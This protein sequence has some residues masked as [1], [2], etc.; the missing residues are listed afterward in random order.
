[1]NSAAHLYGDRSYDKTI[2]PAENTFVEY[3]ALGEGY[4]NYHHVFPYDYSASEL[5]WTHDYNISTWFIDMCAKLGLAWNL[6]K[7]DK[8]VVESRVARTGDQSL[9]E[10]YH[11]VKKT[12][13]LKATFGPIFIAFIGG[14]ILVIAVRQ[15]A[16]LI[17]LLF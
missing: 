6:K 11:G 3:L 14:P 1:M 9:I 2:N 13:S 5:S 15:I 7:V 4:H 17:S 16:A 12:H 8:K 10:A